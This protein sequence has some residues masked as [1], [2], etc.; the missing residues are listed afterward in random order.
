MHCVG[1]LTESSQRRCSLV[2]TGTLKPVNA[3]PQICSTEQ[4]AKHNIATNFSATA[5]TPMNYG[6]DLWGPNINM[7]V[8]LVSALDFAPINEVDLHPL[9]GPFLRFR[10]PRWGRGQVRLD[11]RI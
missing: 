11:K 6:V 4:R 9:T 10:D 3:P 5:A 2:G 7:C 1:R 8:L